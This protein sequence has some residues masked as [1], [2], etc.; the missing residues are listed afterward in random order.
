MFCINCG[1]DIDDKAAICVGCGVATK[2]NDI[3]EKSWITTLLLCIFL[4]GFG[5]HRFYTGY[6]GI[7]VL[8]WFTFAGFFGLWVL[9]DLISILTGNFKT[10]DG[11]SLAK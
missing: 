9:I 1:K 11:R 5:G 8:Y 4:G 3:S 6:T 7:G 2:N 10:K